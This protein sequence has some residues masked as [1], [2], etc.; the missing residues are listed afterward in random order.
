MR[1]LTIGLAMVAVISAVGCGKDDKSSAERDAEVKKVL[2]QGADMEKK[3]YE[4]M[5]KGVENIEKKVQ[6]QKSK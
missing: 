1:H 3:M 2:Q 4:G 6:D 5:Q